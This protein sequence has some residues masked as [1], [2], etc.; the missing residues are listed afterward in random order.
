MPKRNDLAP[1]APGT[2][3]D[4]ARQLVARL[5]V[6][7]RALLLSKPGPAQ[8]ETFSRQEIAVIETVGAE[9]AMTM[10]E[11]ARRVRLPLSTATRVVDRLAGR[12]YVERERPGHNR[13]IVRVSLAPEGRRLFRAAFNARLA[14]ARRM[15]ACL[16]AAERAELVRLFGKVA[17]SVAAD[18]ASGASLE[19]RPV[20]S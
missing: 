18:A 16:S 5:D 19:R 6:A 2:L 7:M 10:G 11:L 9:G 1:D 17:S 15:L 20:S 12:A 13:R 8:G 3:Q 14:A 4:D